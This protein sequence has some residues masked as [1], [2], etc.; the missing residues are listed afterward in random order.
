MSTW[1]VILACAAT[2]YATRLSMVVVFHGRQIPARVHRALSVAGPAVLA[3]LLGA[4]VLAPNGSMEAPPIASVV[5]L[6]AAAAVVRWRDKPLL[7]LAV[8]L[9]VAGAAAALGWT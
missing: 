7:A 4:T 8:G 6:G 2:T 3:A 9:P 5:A 1:L